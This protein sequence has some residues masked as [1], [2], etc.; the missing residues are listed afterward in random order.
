MPGHRVQPE[1][2][3]LFFYLT[4]IYFAHGSDGAAYSADTQSHLRTLGVRGFSA[5]GPG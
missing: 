3:A 5:L 1:P 2:R 4:P